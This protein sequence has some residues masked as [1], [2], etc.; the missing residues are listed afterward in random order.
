M[1]WSTCSSQVVTTLYY[2]NAR[3]NLRCLSW[4]P[5][6]LI[7]TKKWPWIRTSTLSNPKPQS[8]PINLGKSKGPGRR[9][10]SLAWHSLHKYQE[11]S[12]VSPQVS[13]S[14]FLRQ[15][16][17]M[18]VFHSLR[19]W[20]GPAWPAFM[21]CSKAFLRV[22]G[23]QATNEACSG[24]DSSPSALTNP[25]VKNSEKYW[26]F[27]VFHTSMHTYATY[28]V[29]LICFDNDRPVDHCQWRDAGSWP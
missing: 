8:N 28:L 17:A 12:A 15:F 16:H 10:A 5:D 11:G 24:C 14:F 23:Q 9:H 22:S 21:P 19:D 18:R 25:L 1:N 20:P 6:K 26:Y 3:I 2:A 27:N 29:N 4:L 13:P 7:K